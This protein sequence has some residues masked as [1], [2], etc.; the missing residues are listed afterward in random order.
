MLIN[1]VGMQSGGGTAHFSGS[2]GTL[3]V[4]CAPGH[5]SRCT[6]QSNSIPL[7]S[8]VAGSVLG[9]PGL[10][11]SA[12]KSPQPL[13]W[14]LEMTNDLFHKRKD[15]DNAAVILKVTNK[16]NWSLI[17]D[18]SAGGAEGQNLLGETGAV[19]AAD[20]VSRPNGHSAER[21]GHSFGRGFSRHQSAGKPDVDLQKGNLLKIKAVF[22]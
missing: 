11:P 14:L 12:Q 19:W 16:M 2:Y 6:L 15:L 8:L 10:L 1:N 4:K 17:L 9:T 7:L 22:C 21:D 5:P 13:S 3:T 18:F 20:Q